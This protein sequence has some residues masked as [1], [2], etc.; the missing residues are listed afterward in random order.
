MLYA[1]Y[2]TVT[3]SVITYATGYFSHSKVWLLNRVSFVEGGEFT[4]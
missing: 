4:S 2:I 1:T 3:T